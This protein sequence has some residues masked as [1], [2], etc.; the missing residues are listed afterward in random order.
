MHK[1]ENYGLKKID[2]TH[3]VSLM[4]GL[5]KQRI[6]IQDKIDE[7]KK[8][9]DSVD[10]V[11]TQTNNIFLELGIEKPSYD[12]NDL[13]IG[14]DIIFYSLAGGYY[15][16]F[17]GKFVRNEGYAEVENIEMIYHPNDCEYCSHRVG[18]NNIIKIVKER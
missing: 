9:I 7:L 2:N 8:S 15:G 6:E 10:V 5:Y 12:S 13:K 16:I 17:K 11:I 1:L 14:D 4:T 3:Y 18:F